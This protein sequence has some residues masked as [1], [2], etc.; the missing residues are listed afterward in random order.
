MVYWRDKRINTFEIVVLLKVQ[1]AESWSCM[2]MCKLVSTKT[3]K[4]CGRFC[5]AKWRC[6]IVLPDNNKSTPF[7]G[8]QRGPTVS[9]IQTSEVSD[10]KE[11]QCA[12]SAW[13][14]NK[15]YSRH[16]LQW[17]WLAR[18]LRDWDT[19]FLLL[20]VIS[21]YWTYYSLWQNDMWFMQCYANPVVHIVDLHNLQNSSCNGHACC[22]DLVA[23]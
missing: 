19:V 5:E 18:H 13:S 6:P 8:C 17:W 2:A 14:H 7:G 9:L 11:K 3:C 12:L 23:H 15:E 21:N 16:P 22:M 1:M 20:G 10:T 4:W